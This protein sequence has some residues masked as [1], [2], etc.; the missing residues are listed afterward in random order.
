MGLFELHD[1]ERF[2]VYGY[3]IGRGDGSIMAERMTRA[4]DRFVDVSFL[5]DRDAAQ[6][7]ADDAV[8][9]LVD[10]KGFTTDSRPNILSF[11]PAPI[12]VNYL[13][14]PGTMAT[15]HVDYVVVDGTVAP[16]DHQPF[17]DERIVHLPHCYQP[18]DR[19][20]AGADPDARR[21][22]HGLPER[23]ADRGFVFCCFN[24]TYKI[25]PLVFD[26]WMRLLGAVDGSVL[27]PT[28]RR[29][30]TCAG[31]R[32]RAGSTPAASSSRGGSATATT[33]RGWAWPTCSSTRCRSTPTPRP[34]T[35]SGPAC[36]C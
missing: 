15:H 1:R 9:I 25:T 35:R 17:Y 23:E 34:R 14:F 4:L 33:W 31:K 24:N 5:G 16:F 28:G 21:A 27:W 11:R 30:R 26:I 22:D 20:R 6:R 7:I 19:D 18:N 12:Q 13:G 36:R 3:N 8:D 2:E 29:R 32:R 10:L